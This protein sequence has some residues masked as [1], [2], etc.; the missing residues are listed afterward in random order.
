MTSHGDVNERNSQC[1]ML[2]KRTLFQPTTIVGTYLLIM[3]LAMPFK[4]MHTFHR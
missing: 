2:Y 3:T 4:T 1:S